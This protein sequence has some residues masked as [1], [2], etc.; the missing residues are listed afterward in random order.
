MRISLT[1]ESL[2]SQ[3]PS[4]LWTPSGHRLLQ[5]ADSSGLWTPL[6]RRLLLVFGLLHMAYTLVGAR[7]LV[8]VGLILHGLC[9]TCIEEGASRP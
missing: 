6:G 7:L 5:V 2:G 3:T 4:D 8:Q 9:Q 1:V